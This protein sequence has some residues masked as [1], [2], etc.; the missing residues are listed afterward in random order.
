MSQR[1]LFQDVDRGRNGFA[2]AVLHRLGQIHLVEEHVAQ[3]LGRIDVELDPA[4]FVDF[5]GLGVDFALQ[6]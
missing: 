5:A 6:S 3:L 1:Q 4:E 2:F